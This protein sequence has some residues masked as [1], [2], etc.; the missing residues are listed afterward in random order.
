MP[1]SP[2]KASGLR[3]WGFGVGGIGFL[4]KADQRPHPMD[5]T[6]LPINGQQHYLLEE[7]FIEEGPAGK[8]I[9]RILDMGKRRPAQGLASSRSC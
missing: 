7:A 3:Y 6:P 8:N 9:A 1:P 2:I 5:A 4:V